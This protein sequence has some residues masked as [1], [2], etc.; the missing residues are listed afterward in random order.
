MTLRK[1]N[2]STPETV[3]KAVENRNALTMFN[4]LS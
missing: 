1:R 2:S 4:L 3:L